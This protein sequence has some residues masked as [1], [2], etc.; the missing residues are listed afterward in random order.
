MGPC[1]NNGLSRV[2]VLEKKKTLKEQLEGLQKANTERM[3]DLEEK[4]ARTRVDSSDD[5][6]SSTP[7]A[8]RVDNNDDNAT[9]T[10]ERPEPQG[11]GWKILKGEEAADEH[12]ADIKSEASHRPCIYVAR[13]I[14][15]CFITPV[16]RPRPTV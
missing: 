6:E 1:D 9:S 5:N 14:S 3:H 8:T 10:Q 12:K 11:K 13:C 7:Q 15:F 4:R 2:Q 16:R